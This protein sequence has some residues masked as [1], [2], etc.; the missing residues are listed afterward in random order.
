MNN[1][2]LKRIDEMDLF[3]DIS[4][5]GHLLIACQHILETNIP[6]F[7]TLI[8]KGLKPQ[9]IF[10]LGKAYSTNKEVLNEL[11]KKGIC[12]DEGSISFDS[13]KSFDDQFNLIVKEFLSNIKNKV[14]FS[15]YKKVILLDDGGN[16]I[17]WANKIFEDLSNFFAIE[18]TSSGYN[19][20]QNEKLKFSVVNVARSNTKLKQESPHIAEVVVDKLKFQLDKL[21]LNPRKVLIIGAGPL[22]MEVFNRLKKDFDVQKYDKLEDLSDF[23]NPFLDS[24]LG[25]FDMIVGT[26][27]KEIINVSS[28]KYLKKGVILASA[29][30]SDREFQAES[31]RKLLPKSNNCHENAAV[32]S[33]ILLNS[34]FPINFDGGRISVEMSKIQLTRGLMLGAIY[35]SIINGY[36]KGII[37]LDNQFQEGVMKFSNK[38]F[39]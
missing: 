14:D 22:G 17:Y 7:E 33:I 18:Q 10:L 8:K 32:K 37:E 20:L 21:K 13:H 12:V 9:N 29:S 11:G 26:T 4:L 34:G 15:N 38:T 19:L 36:E 31:L 30:S 39:K 25:K 27:G 5:K 35:L 2:L 24:I 3:S 28:H 6:L 16:I 23:N 1:A